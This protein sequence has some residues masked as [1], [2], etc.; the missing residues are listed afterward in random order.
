MPV[1]VHDV[2]DFRDYALARIS[3]GGAESMVELFREWLAKQETEQ[4]L[5]AIR[6]GIA[7][8]DAGR[9]GPYQEFMA[10]VRDRFDEENVNDAIREGIADIESGR[11]KGFYRSQDEFRAERGLPPRS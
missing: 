10:E 8:V 4:A 3:N 2:N 5:E 9:T 7:D 1:T 6:E 11:T